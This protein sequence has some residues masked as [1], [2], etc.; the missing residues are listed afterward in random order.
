MVTLFSAG[1]CGDV[2]HIDVNWSE[3]QRGFGNAARMG[4]I[5]A[6]EVLRTWPRFEPV[7]TG[8][9]PRQERRRAPAAPRDRRDRSREGSG[10]RRA[11]QDPKS[12]R[13][14]FLEMV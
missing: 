1:C 12:K 3:P 5:L 10:N 2:N 6:G 8:P 7:D 9:I 13:P 4:T 14:T 11:S